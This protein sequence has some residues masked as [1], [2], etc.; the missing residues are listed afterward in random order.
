MNR[1]E[2]YGILSSTFKTYFIII[3]L[4]YP[5]GSHRVVCFFNAESQK[6]LKYRDCTDLERNSNQKLK[7]GVYKIY[8]DG[9]QLSVQAYCDMSTDG[10][11]WT[12]GHAFIYIIVLKIVYKL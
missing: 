4:N 12:V 10:G 8:P 6:E 7:N 11:G 3:C 9:E 5:S 1:C 2:K